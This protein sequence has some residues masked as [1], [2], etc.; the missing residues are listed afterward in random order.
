MDIKLKKATIKD[1]KLVKNLEESAVSKMFAPEEDYKRF[2]LE[3]K[4]FIIMD[5]EKSIGTVSYKNQ[6]DGNILINGLTIIS[7]YREQGIAK[8]AMGKLLDMVGN[9]NF[10]LLVHPAN[11][12]AL[13]IYL[14]FGF[15]I[16]DWKDN[17]FNDG[18][19]RL[20][21]QRKMQ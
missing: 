17:Y 6:D 10:E 12:P 14:S 2:V 15:I 19:P 1:W 11:T 18:E 16:S 8:Q 20:Y 3:S 7:E 4:V 21:L 5:K 13:L 9:K